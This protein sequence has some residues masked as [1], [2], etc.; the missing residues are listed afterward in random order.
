MCVM[1]MIRNEAGLYWCMNRESFRESAYATVFES[2][3]R[4][5]KHIR[6]NEDAFGT[7]H[8]IVEEVVCL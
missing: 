1:Y 3:F 6:E 5:Y 4:A 8:L 7:D 2:R